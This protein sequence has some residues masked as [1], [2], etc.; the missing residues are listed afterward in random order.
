MTAKEAYNLYREYYKTNQW[1]GEDVRNYLKPNWI[2]FEEYD[3]D[4]FVDKVLTDDKFNEKWGNGC[5]EELKQDK[6]ALR[7]S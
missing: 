7:Q 3:F 5:K 1:D 6:D 2:D 4:E